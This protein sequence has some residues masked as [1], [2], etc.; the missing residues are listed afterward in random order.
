MIVYAAVLEE[1][2]TTGTMMV[3]W[4]RK[5][6]KRDQFNTCVVCRFRITLSGLISDCST[7]VPFFLQRQRVYHRP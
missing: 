1:C 3:H 7:T 5:V 6:E 4:I 2:P